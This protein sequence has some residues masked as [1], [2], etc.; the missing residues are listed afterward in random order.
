M[1]DLE[2]DI[3]RI[4]SKVKEE[5]HKV[6]ALQFPEG[7]RRRSLEISKTIGSNT[8]AQVILLMDPCFGACDMPQDARSLGATLLVHL[9]HAQMPGV[10]SDVETLYIEARSSIEPVEVIEKVLPSLIPPIALVTT[11]QHVDALDK[12]ME[13]LAIEGMEV[14]I[15]DGGPRAP[16]PGMVLGCDISS[17]LIVK[18]RASSFLFLGSGLFHP[19]A[20]ALGTGK[21]TFAAD[22]Y[23]GEILDLTSELEPFLRK[24]HA[25]IAKSMDANTFGILIG[26]KPG[27]KRLGLAKELA[28]QVRTKGKTAYLMAVDHLSPD[29]ILGMEVD[30]YVSTLCPRL[31]IDDSS[32][33]SKPLLTPFELKVVLG[34]ADYNEYELDYITQL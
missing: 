33:Y 16:Y 4:I 10:G 2:L 11:V 8:G 21:P 20:I 19:R 28:D 31:A 27:Q 17:A 7:L 32:Y 29:L 34:V 26:R 18:D 23:T 14:V 22:P 1:S 13:F 6:I 3:D 15:P 9:G 30:V 24:R 12:V 5:G 25:L